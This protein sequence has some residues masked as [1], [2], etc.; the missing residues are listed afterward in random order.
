MGATLSTAR[1]YILDIWPLRTTSEI[2]TQQ[3]DAVND[4]SQ[5]L[6]QNQ[7]N[8]RLNLINQLLRTNSLR[9]NGITRPKTK[10][11]N[12]LNDFQNVHFAQNYYMAGRKFKNLIDQNQTFLFGDQLDLGFVLSHKPTNFP[13]DI[14]PIDSP[15]NYIQ[16]LVNIRKDTLKLVKLNDSACYESAPALNSELRVL[17]PNNTNQK[18]SIEFVFDCDCDVEIKIHF[19]A[20]EKFTDS[21][22]NSERKL[23]Y[24]CSCL[25]HGKN[26]I[27]INST[28]KPKPVIYKKGSNL[29][30]KQHEYFFVPSDFPKNVWQFNLH[31]GY[32]PIVIECIPIDES[33]RDRHSHVTLAYLDKLQTSINPSQPNT[34]SLNLA[35]PI[36][37]QTELT[38][39]QEKT[40]KNLGHKALSVG[41]ISQITTTYQIKAIKQK[42]Y[43]DG[44]VYSL[45]EIYGIEKKTSCDDGST[46]SLSNNSQETTTTVSTIKPDD[47]EQE[48]KGIECVICMSEIRDTLILPCRHLCLCKLCAYNLRVQSNNCPICRM[49]FIALIQIKLYK[50]KSN[51][52]ADNLPIVTLKDIEQEKDSTI[53]IQIDN[54][55]ISGM[56]TKDFQ[57]KC[58]NSNGKKEKTKK[59]K[60]INENYE[61]V[62][63]FDVFKTEENL[64]RSKPKNEKT[65]EIIECVNEIENCVP[66]MIEVVNVNLDQVLNAIELPN[67]VEKK[68]MSVNIG[69]NESKINKGLITRSHVDLS[70]NQQQECINL[71]KLNTNSFSCI[72]GQNSQVF[73]Q[74]SQI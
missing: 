25:K 7:A 56:D 37:N 46:N 43:I 5:N 2:E 8:S 6:N 27:C 20:M 13:Y 63:L 59:K 19:F 12:C 66:E 71:K 45:Q 15:S 9:T 38:T 49:P 11:L 41:C 67:R 3:S 23:T 74:T 60:R 62:T 53:I 52:E 69:S 68:S 26:C 35:S 10:N 47:Q 29:V 65:D 16:S 40:D 57:V 50:K 24:T 42:Q 32:F 21:P 1:N 34:E 33:H 54:N 61:H 17:S 55:K 22:N 30:F 51:I 44:I 48:L 64:K 18:Y 4:E 58:E 39:I 14:K 36:S 72:Q 73:R 31:T 70:K 28:N